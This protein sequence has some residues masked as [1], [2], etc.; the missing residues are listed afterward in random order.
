[1]ARLNL[2]KL[3]AVG[4][5]RLAENPSFWTGLKT[6]A[7]NREFLLKIGVAHESATMIR[8]SRLADISD[9]IG[10]A[11]SPIVE[12]TGRLAK[13]LM[14]LTGLA[15][16]TDYMK[17]WAAS[18]TQNEMVYKLVDWDNLPTATKTQFAELGI[19]GQIAKIFNERYQKYGNT[20]KNGATDLNLDQWTDDILEQIRAIESG[21]EILEQTL[22]MSS[23]QLNNIGVVVVQKGLKGVKVDKAAKSVIVDSPQAARRLNAALDE[24]QTNAKGAKRKSISEAREKLARY[25]LD[26]DGQLEGLKARLA[27]IEATQNIVKTA[28]FRNSERVLVSPSELDMPPIFDEEF[29]KN[30]FQFKS[31]SLS[32]HNQF[33]APMIDRFRGGDRR[34]ARMVAYG[35]FGGMMTEAL[36]LAGQGRIEELERYNG[37]DWMMGFNAVDIFSRNALTEQ[38]GATMPLSR[39]SQRSYTG[40]L[41]PSVGLMQQAMDASGMF[42][43]ENVTEHQIR[44]FRR[45]LPFNNL[46]WTHLEPRRLNAGIKK[47]TKP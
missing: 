31:F 10:T 32:S 46:L 8:M 9:P 15:E 33:T 21:E 39:Y 26:S 3:G 30:I 11:P 1:M 22:A 28:I 4:A 42:F 14:S 13:N 12:A 5:S 37:M 47:E 35:A 2:A 20:F 24:L 36:K 43:G 6:L 25:F 34:V 45:L 19:D 27:E 23:G 41:G 7:K 16:W 29:A 40:P 44:S 38:L 18:I 17:L